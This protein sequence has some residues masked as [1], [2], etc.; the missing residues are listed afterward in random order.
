MAWG[1]GIV[2][3]DAIYDAMDELYTGYQ[4]T[5]WISA[6]ASKKKHGA[7]TGAYGWMG[8]AGTYTGVYFGDNYGYLAAGPPPPAEVAGHGPTAGKLQSKLRK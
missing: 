8:V 5:E 6:K 3:G 1:K 2:V 4:W 7:F